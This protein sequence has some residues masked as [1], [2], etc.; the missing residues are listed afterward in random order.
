MWPAYLVEALQI[1]EEIFPVTWVEQVFSSIL[2]PLFTITIS[3]V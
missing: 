3:Q 2:G 1:Q